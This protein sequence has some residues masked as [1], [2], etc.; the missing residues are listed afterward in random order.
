MKQYFN[1]YYFNVDEDYLGLS[2]PSDVAEEYDSQVESETDT[3]DRDSD[4]SPE[5]RAE[6]KER[7]R[8]ERLEK[9]EKKAAKRRARVWFIQMLSNTSNV[10]LLAALLFQVHCYIKY[11][12]HGYL[13]FHNYVI[14]ML[15]IQ[16]KVRDAFVKI[17][18]TSHIMHITFLYV[19]DM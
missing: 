15:S 4:E 2:S 19:L 18:L 17:N 16:S 8:E 11:L 5:Q 10:S 1:V 6:R 9:A 3:D 12:M 14:Q 13:K 7:Q